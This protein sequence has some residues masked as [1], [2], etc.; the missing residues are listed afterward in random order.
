[1]ESVKSN[2]IKYVLI[3]IFN[4]LVF[5]I[6][7][8][9]PGYYMYINNMNVVLTLRSESITHIVLRHLLVFTVLFLTNFLSFKVAKSISYKISGN[10]I[11][12]RIIC[13]I[14]YIELFIL[15]ILFFRNLKLVFFWVF[16]YDYL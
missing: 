4:C 14:F 8:V 2:Y 10:K 6:P 9:R 12:Y 15:A 5:V 1:M 11:K 3:W 13:F 16:F 7:L